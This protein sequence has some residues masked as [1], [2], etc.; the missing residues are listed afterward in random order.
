MLQFQLLSGLKT[1]AK[2]GA[3]LYYWTI[4][5]CEINKTDGWIP[6]FD[7]W[8]QKIYEKKKNK[9]KYYCIFNIKKENE[10]PRKMQIQTDQDQFIYL[11]SVEMELLLS[12]KKDNGKAQHW[13]VSRQQEKDKSRKNMSK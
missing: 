2:A 11:L 5:I 12:L 1:K 4:E 13:H 9:K 7:K 3:V 8:T 10:K 6:N